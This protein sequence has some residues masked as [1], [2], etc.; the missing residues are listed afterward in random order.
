VTET[1][2]GPVWYSDV[3]VNIFTNR[4]L[5]WTDVGLKKSRDYAKTDRLHVIS[6]CRDRSPRRDQCVWRDRIGN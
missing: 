2:W 1:T 5:S 6:S 4:L 3:P